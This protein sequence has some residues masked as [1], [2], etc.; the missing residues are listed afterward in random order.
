MTFSDDATVQNIHFDILQNIE[1]R[2]G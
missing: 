2:E 1:Y